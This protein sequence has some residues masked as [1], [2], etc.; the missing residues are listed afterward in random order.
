[1]VKKEYPDEGEL[2]VGTV[3]K[4]QNFGAFVTLN[5]FPKKEGFIHIAEVATGWVKRIRNHIK[6]KQ[7]VVCKVMH[8]DRAKDHVDLSLKRVNEHQK[9]DKIQEWKNTQ[10]SEKLIEMVAKQIGKTVEQCYK[11]FA[12][13]LI[14]KYGLLYTAFEE[15]AYDIETLKNDGFTGDWLKAFE[16]VAKISI[17]IPFVDIRGYI[18]VTS[19]LPDGVNHIKNVLAEAEESEFEDVEIQI[20][21]IGAPQY[22]ITVKAPDY[23]IA[24]EEMR[25]AVDKIKESIK[26]YNGDC[27]FHRKLEE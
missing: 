14:K 15:A 4:V 2:I 25:K 9:R 17:S 23:K 8:V 19:W 5:E 24:E 18:I 13:E 26:K 16:E 11:D 21:Y 22:M 3:V 20:K 10:K 12:S 6:E 7:K 27:E 1:M